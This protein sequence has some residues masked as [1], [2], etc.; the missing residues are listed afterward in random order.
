MDFKRL[1]ST[2]KCIRVWPHTHTHTHTEHGPW[3]QATV[4]SGESSFALCDCPQIRWAKTSDGTVT[5]QHKSSESAESKWLR[6]AFSYWQENLRQVVLW[7]AIEWLSAKWRHNSRCKARLI[8]WEEVCSHGCPRRKKILKFFSLFLQLLP[9]K[10][11]LVSS[12]RS[13]VLWCGGLF[14]SNIDLGGRHLGSECQQHRFLAVWPWAS[15]LTSLCLFLLICK[16]VP[17]VLCGHLLGLLW[18]SYEA[19]Y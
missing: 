2:R 5:F 18:N 8:V 13:F 7:E 14:E 10:S 15:Y 9:T 4:H 12:A 17:L 6:E 16:M 19:L 3:A 1:S 11:L